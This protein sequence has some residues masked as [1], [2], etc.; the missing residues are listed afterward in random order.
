M[1]SPAATSAEDAQ[2][3]LAESIAAATRSVHAKLNKIIIARLPLAIPPRAA[4]PSLYASG[5]LHITPIYDTF[6]S[7]WKTI[8]ESPQLSTPG[9]AGDDCKSSQAE[10]TPVLNVDS[11]PRHQPALCERTRSILTSLYLPGLMRSDRLRADIGSI[12]GWSPDVVNEQLS[13]ISQSGRLAEFTG[14]VRRTIE[15]KPHVLMAYSYILFMALFAGGRF[16]RATLESAGS[17]FWEQT[18]S[19]IPP[20]EIPCQERTPSSD[21]A[22]HTTTPVDM[23]RGD[24]RGK[25][26]V[27]ARHMRHSLPLSF[28]HF[29]TPLDGEDLKKEFK[30]RLTESE[31]LLTPRERHDIIQE[32][33]CIFD[34]MLLLVGQLD[35]V[36]DT[37]LEHGPSVLESWASLAPGGRLRDSVAIARDRKREK[38]ASKSSEDSEKSDSWLSRHTRQ[39]ACETLESHALSNLEKQPPACCPASKSMRFEPKL[40]VPNRK[41]KDQTFS[42]DG[43]ANAATFAG[44][45]MSRQGQLSRSATSLISNI[46]IVAGL[47]AIVSIF[48]LAKRTGAKGL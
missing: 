19:P 37:D 9:D 23:A 41:E 43:A 10:L 12:T 33:V 45:A 29:A 40:A 32:A 2:R 3:P 44:G 21:T 13:A 6:E 47:A 11:N 25:I 22:I 48:F 15:K 20:S 31:H 46:I 30:K 36:C 26:Q 18:P 38:T 17:E 1:T 4:D 24:D 27:G 7:L 14:H 16:I 5:L 34:N 39:K 42:T 28:F 8:A 35:S